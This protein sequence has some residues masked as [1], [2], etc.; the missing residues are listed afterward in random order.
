MCASGIRLWWGVGSGQGR[1]CDLDG[2]MR[3][4]LLYRVAVGFTGGGLFC[5]RE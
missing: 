1:G 2:F 5:G 3:Q 4:R